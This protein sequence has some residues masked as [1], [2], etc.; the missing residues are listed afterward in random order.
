MG[1]VV[2]N[3]DYICMKAAGARFYY[4]YEVTRC[5]AAGEEEWCFEFVKGAMHIVIPFSELGA[6]DKFNVQECFMFGMKCLL[7]RGHLSIERCIDFDA[8]DRER[9]AING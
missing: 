4:G 7:E 5:N 6:R 3:D 2:V 1:D 9:A 8:I